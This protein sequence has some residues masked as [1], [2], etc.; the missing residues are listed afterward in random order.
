MLNHLYISKGCLMHI[1]CYE[2]SV[3]SIEALGNVFL[4]FSLLR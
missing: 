2:M 1:F 3:D 4:V